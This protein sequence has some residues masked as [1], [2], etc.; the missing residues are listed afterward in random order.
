M[1]I[2][3]SKPI[4]YD[5]KYIQVDAGVRYWQDSTVNGIRDTDC[6]DTYNA[7]T[8]PCAE[9]V[10]KQNLI[11]SGEDWRWRPLIDIEIGQVVNWRKG[12]TA[13]LHYKV[14]DDFYCDILDEDKGVIASYNGYVPNVMC[15]SDDGYGDYIIMSIDDNGFILNWNKWS[16]LELIKN[17]D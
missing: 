12:V 11:N 17:D 7:P 14:C 13:N 3:I 10:G 8:I 15:P 6:D 2:T 5:A 9:Y 16:I 4:E 1:K